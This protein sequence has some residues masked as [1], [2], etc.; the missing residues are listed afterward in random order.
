MDP[1]DLQITGR[2]CLAGLLGGLVGLEREVHSQPAGL[3]THMIVALGSCLIMLV[4][5]QMGA[6]NPGRGDPARIA[7]QV[8]A[9]VGFLGAGAI[10]RSGLSVRGLTTAACLWTV[11]AIGLSVGCGYWLAALVTTGL[12]LLALTVFQKVERRFSKGKSFRRF[13]VQAKDSATLVA[14]LETILRQQNIGIQ[15]LD[16]QRD[17]VEKKLQV[18]ITAICPEQVDMDKLSRAFS[19]L[20]EVEKVDID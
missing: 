20:P 5:I 3:R 4:S 11:A 8:V 18:S 9:G 1:A 10:M 14:Q 15:E 2:L 7:A 19:A 6:L 16:L 12:T 17:L 13:I